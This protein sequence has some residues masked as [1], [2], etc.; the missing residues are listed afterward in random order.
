MNTLRKLLVAFGAIVGPAVIGFAPVQAVAAPGDCKL[1][2]I[3][4]WPV[5]IDRNRISVQGTINGQSIGILLDTGAERSLIQRSAAARLGIAPQSATGRRMFGV[6]GETQVEVAYV[7]ELRIGEAVSKGLYVLVAGEREVRDNIALL[8]GADFFANFDIE[9]DLPHN[10]VRLYQSRECDGAWLAYWGGES[11]MELPMESGSRIVLPVKINGES[12]RALLDSGAATSVLSAADA[13]RLGVTPETH[14]VMPGGCRQG[15]GQKLVDAWI[16][17]FRS[18]AI[19]NE[20]I[21]DPKIYFADLWRHS[22][23]TPTGSHLPRRLAGLPDMLLGA[24][25]LRAHRVL[26]SHSQRKVYF[27]YTGG[28]VFPTREAKL[29]G[30]AAT[31]ERKANE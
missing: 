17:Q 28:T 13:R 14:G 12:I 21:S 10:A 20:L 30:E 25:F 19:D 2:R 15:L 4:E 27:T 24:D 16:G 5:Q 1:A 22:T 26:I 23:Y 7:D 11:T 6:G 18:F 29:C 31:G 9:F 8:L 3:A